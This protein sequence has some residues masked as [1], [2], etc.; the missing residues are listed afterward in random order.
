MFEV[1]LPFDV[2]SRTPRMSRH[3][4][5]AGTRFRLLQCALSLLQG[6]QLTRSLAKN[7]LRERIY[8]VR[9]FI[10]RL[11]AYCSFLFGINAFVSVLPFRLV[12]TTFAV[13]SSAQCEAAPSCARMR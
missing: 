3:P 10:E 6:D 7:L 2:G 12:W 1:T 8:Q 4:A 9:H 13:D 11:N 5:A